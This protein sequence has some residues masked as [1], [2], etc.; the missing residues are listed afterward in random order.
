MGVVLHIYRQRSAELFFGGG[1]GVN[2]EIGMF[3][4]L[5]TVPVS[6]WATIVRPSP[7]SKVKFSIG[8]TS[9]NQKI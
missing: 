8:I 3:W 4:L 5:V 7:K 1:V 2:F 6:F 9:H